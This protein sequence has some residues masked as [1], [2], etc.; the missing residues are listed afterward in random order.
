MLVARRG[1]ILERRAAELSNRYGVRTHVLVQDLTMPEAT[2]NIASECERLGWMIEVL[3]NNAGYPITGLFH[4]MSWSEVDAALCILVKSVVELTHRFLPQMVAR[5][6]G[7]VI[8]VAS[9]AAFEPGSYRSSLYSSSKAFV[10]GFSE[11]VAAE[12]VN[13]GVTVTAL[14][15]GFTKTEWLSHNKLENT[16]VPGFLWMES[17][18]VAEI[19]YRSAQRGKTVAVAGRSALRAIYTLFRMAPRRIVGNM[20]SKKRRSMA[21]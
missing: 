3:V 8:N 19:G 16:A 18:A 14:C 2:E 1:E 6:S 9:M 17:D 21:T 12:L 7:K 4:K 10:V 5:G 11:S 13:T 20:L 15:P